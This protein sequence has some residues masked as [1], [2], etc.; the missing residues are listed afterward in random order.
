MNDYNSMPQTAHRLELTG[1]ERL[2]V[3]GVEDVERFD[4]TGIVMSTSAGTLVV[5]GED[6]HIGKLS[7]D[8][9]E[10][11]VEGRVDSVTYEDD[12]AGRGGFFSRLFG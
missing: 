7:L 1:R 8:G 12:G 9:G 10:L 4:E 3:S 6:L 5:T 11:H 2:T